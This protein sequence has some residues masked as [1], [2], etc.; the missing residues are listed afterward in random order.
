MVSV[1]RLL[2]VFLIYMLAC[3]LAVLAAEPSGT[4]GDTVAPSTLPTTTELVLANGLKVLLIEDHSYPVV[5]CLSWYKVGSRNERAGSTGITHLLEHMMFGNVGSLRKG[6]I[7]AQIARCGGQFNG[8]TSDDFTAF[9]ETLP[10]Q[11][12]DLALRI[13]SERMRG[14]QFTD[15]DVQEE[16]NNIQR[17][18]EVQA[19]DP[20]AILEQEVRSMLY[21]AHPYHNP[22]I[23][24]RVD[25]ESTT[26]AQL[27]TYYDKYFG[28]S[29]CTLVIAGDFQKKTAIESVERYFAPLPKAP[30]TVAPLKF[31]QEQ[32]R[33]ERRS[34]VKYPGKQEALS[35]A[36]HAPALDDADAPA[37]VVLEKLLNSPFS[38]RL[39]TKLVDSRTCAAATAVFEPKKDPGYFAVNCTAL[40]GTPNAQQKL[41]DGVDS[42]LAQVRN[43]I[44]SDAEL[45][46]ARNQAEFAFASETEG[47]YRAG[48]H[49]GYFDTLSNWNKVNTWPEQIRAVTAADLQR[50][51]KR[52][53][54]GDNRVIA[55][56]AGTAAPKP[57]APKPESAPAPSGKPAG[58]PSKPEH[59]HLTGFKE[60]DNSL[61]R[62][63]PEAMPNAIPN[64]VQ[65]LPKVIN[66]APKEV[67]KELPNAVEKVPTVIKNIPSA[68]GS[69]PSVIRQIPSTLGSVPSA[70]KELPGAIVGVPGAAAGAVKDLPAAIVGIP[71]AA[72]NAVKELPGAIVGVPG[73]TA[74][75][76]KAMPAAIG[77]F[78]TELG[79]IPSAIGRQLM[80]PQEQRLANGTVRRTLRNGITLV[81]HESHLSPIVQIAGASRAGSAYEP[82]SKKGLSAVVAALLNQGNAR[83]G[84]TQL[85]TMQEDLGIAVPYMVTFDN[86]A[87]KLQFTTRCLSRDV[88]AQLD[89]IAETVTNPTF[90]DA[91]FERAKQDAGNEIQRNEDSNGR[92]ADRAIYRSILTQGSP[93]VPDSPAELMKSISNLS[94]ADAKKFVATNISPTGTTIV[95]VGDIDI[96]TATKLVEKS[97]GS[98]MSQGTHQKLAA[99]PNARQVTRTAVPTKDKSKTTIAFGRLVTGMHTVP[100]YANVLIADAAFSKHPFMSRLSQKM[101][102]DE[103]FAKA[104]GDAGLDTTLSRIGD[105]AAWSLNIE[106]EP[107]T[108]PMTVNSIQAELQRFG[109]EGLTQTEFIEARRYLLGSIPVRQ[110]GTIGSTAR[111]LLDGAMRAAG[112]DPEATLLASVRNS[113]LETVNRAIKHSLRPEVATMVVVGT[114]QSMRATRNQAVTGQM[115]RPEQPAEQQAEQA[116]SNSDNQ[117]AKESSAVPGNAVH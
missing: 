47:P 17:E 8:Y 74:G 29:N 39:R 99:H 5:S 67:I 36:F 52:Y 22:I 117:A 11:R 64:A 92:K 21:V 13:E 105:G 107:N 7:G 70:V 87:E 12:L 1:A 34:I 2:A 95:M 82:A 110:L 45:R 114:S 20:N 86:D 97:F 94:V 84:R 55:W 113:N 16:L 81:V 69:I 48:F 83:R 93:F 3:P 31:G 14:V 23:G 62:K 79:G 102:A 66:N 101:A 46:R 51:A 72:A 35:V 30:A 6:V 53:L 19:R 44:V 96:D 112:E 106:V 76:L 4:T 38:G 28:P 57:A 25:L 24:W 43:Q 54:S 50:V 58:T 77:A 68:V 61:G 41:L 104:I 9:F 27:K 40:P 115:A 109:K 85:L 73:A 78:A 26:A 103:A 89:N 37:M 65:N 49:C 56:L 90:A 18:F 10:A 80:G 63:I 32:Q 100:E 71:G 42:V 75:A 59:V 88:S 111:T 91:D 15:A 116:D 108:V 33:G 98:W 60:D